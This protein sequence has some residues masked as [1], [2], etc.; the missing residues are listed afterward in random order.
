MC[1]WVG[2]LRVYI[3]GVPL[4]LASELLPA[5]KFNFGL[6]TISTFMPGAKKIFR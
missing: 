3:D 2:W 5:E 1:A 4:D 6:L